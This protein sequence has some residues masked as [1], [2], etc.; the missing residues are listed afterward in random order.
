M[1]PAGLLRQGIDPLPFK[2]ESIRLILPMP[3]GAAAGT[4]ISAVSM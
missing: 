2:L 3:L 1:G 4:F